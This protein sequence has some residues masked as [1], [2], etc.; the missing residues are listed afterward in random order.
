MRLFSG[1]R[2]PAVSEEAEPLP[3]KFVVVEES[4]GR[5]VLYPADAVRQV[6]PG[7]QGDVPP[8]SWPMP[9]GRVENLMT[10]PW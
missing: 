4:I 3:G 2:G 6:G 10:M 1:D 9:N 5:F 7:K 8:L